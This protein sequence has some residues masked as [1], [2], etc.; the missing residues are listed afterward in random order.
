MTLTASAGEL[1]TLAVYLAAGGAITGLLAGLFGIGGG[2]VIVPV[3][4]QLF[5]FMG[6]PE[7]VRMHLCIG[8]SLAAIIPTSYRA[9]RA[10]QAR[11]AV[12]SAIIRQLAA[13]VIVGAV[14][15]TVIAA[16]HSAARSDSASETLPVHS[17][18]AL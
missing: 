13:P 3:L 6:V 15:G 9:Y 1:A 17:R 7:S 10:H 12:D 14:L 8:T 2:T 18:Y 16:E 4:Y 11:G 5:G